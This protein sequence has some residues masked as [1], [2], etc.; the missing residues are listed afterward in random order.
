MT[1]TVRLILAGLVAAALAVSLVGCMG[2]WFTQT[3][4]ASLIIGDPVVSGGTYTQQS[5]WPGSMGQF[6]FSSGRVEQTPI[7]VPR[8]GGT[9]GLLVAW[10]DAGGD[11]QGLW[12][13]EVQRQSVDYTWLY[14][15]G[16]V[17][18]L[19]VVMAAVVL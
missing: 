10:R 5:I 18:V 3:Q 17:L 14:V 15:L 4:K 13:W 12:V 16:V 8:S 2:N 7:T 9:L 19:G 6:S 11:H 1:S